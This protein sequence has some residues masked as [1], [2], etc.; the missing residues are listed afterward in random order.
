MNATEAIIYCL[1]NVETSNN[2]TIF[3]TS[4]IDKVGAQHWV[5]WDKGPQGDLMAPSLECESC[6]PPF[7]AC[8]EP[9]R[10]LTEEDTQ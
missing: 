6:F 8:N 1:R 2:N 3:S 5:E 7:A 9:Y 4:V 10:L